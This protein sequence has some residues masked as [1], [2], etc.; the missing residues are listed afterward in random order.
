M[1]KKNPKN[2]I[3]FFVFIF[4]LFAA[5]TV[6]KFYRSEYNNPLMKEKISSLDT[7]FIYNIYGSQDP[8][9]Q[10]RL[11]Y[12]KD[13]AGINIIAYLDLSSEASRYFIEQIFPQLNQTYIDAGIL[14]Y[15]Y[16]Y[17]LTNEDITR[18]SDNFR[19]ASALIC[20]KEIKE[21]AYS[22]LYFDIIRNPGIEQ[23]PKLLQNHGIPIKD[24]NSCI[25]KN[26]FDELYEDALEVETF[27]MAGLNQRFYIGITG[28]DNTVLD[29]VP[30]YRKFE[31]AIIEYETQLGN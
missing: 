28:T 15:Y 27:G 26:G 8:D 16:K 23:L 24:Y 19:Y 25:S 6:V 31:R 17:Y 4:L 14:K 13:S 11:Y 2:V 3:C 9:I 29:G 12:G 21:E 20:V 30:Q 18:K 5:I 10:N 1:R 22:D 7:K